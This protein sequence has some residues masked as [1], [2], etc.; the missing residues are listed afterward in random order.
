VHTINKKSDRKV[1]LTFLTGDNHILQSCSSVLDI[2]A[3]ACLYFKDA[4]PPEIHVFFP[5]GTNLLEE[6]LPAPPRV[7][8]SLVS[9]DRSRVAFWESS[10]FALASIGEK[11][12]RRCLDELEKLKTDYIRRKC[13]YCIE[14]NEVGHVEALL[15]NGAHVNHRF[16]NGDTP[17]TIASKHG[18]TEVIRTLLHH[19]AD[20]NQKTLKGGT[21]LNCACF[22]GNSEIMEMLLKR[23]A[24]VNRSGG[25]GVTAL[26]LASLR[27][28]VE[29]VGALLRSA[30]NINESSDNGSTALT[31]ASQRGHKDVVKILLQCRDIYPNYERAAALAAQKG[32]TEIVKVL[33]NNAKTP[34]RGKGIIRKRKNTTERTVVL[35]GFF[36]SIFIS[37]FIG[38]VGFFN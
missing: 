17:L 14:N 6:A 11:K 27:G 34:S 18:R 29:I 37:I 32:Y 25:D 5:G 13:R 9:G 26:M 23:N 16:E 7:S 28:H 12:A 15:E 3:R 31:L 21:P 8:A 24:D 1:H 2:K 33:Q 30:A 22:K 38:L 35:C 4:Y 36:V 10:F 19:T 20:V